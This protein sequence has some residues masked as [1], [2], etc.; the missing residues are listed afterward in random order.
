MREAIILAGGL[1]TRLRSAV[2]NV[3]KSMAPIGETPF[4]EVLL[5]QL[6]GQNFKRII[7]ATGFMSPSV[8]HYFGN[9]YKGMSIQYSVEESPLG[10]GGAIRLASTFCSSEYVFVMN[11]DS[12]VNFD[13]DEMESLWKNFNHPVVAVS[14]VADVSRY[15]ALKIE[16]GRIIAFQEKHQNPDGVG[17]QGY[18]NAG[19]YLFPVQTLYSLQMRIPFSFEA[20]FLA[21]KASTLD[22]LVHFT[23]G[24]FID[25]GIP[26]D[27]FRAKE[28]LREYCLF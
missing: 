3:P 8:S 16:N 2:S 27:Y 9:N 17:A 28:V 26:E 13:A 18:I 4:L 22:L 5:N 12:F 20:E 25:I 10:T 21:P 7:L 19:C 24:A 14:K 6:V 1:G 23:S 15:G 11:G